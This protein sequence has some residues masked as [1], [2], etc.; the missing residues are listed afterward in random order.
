MKLSKKEAKNEFEV[1]PGAPKFP[2]GL[3]INLDN[4]SL[5]KLGF[6]SLP[7]V[8][9][10]FIVVGIGPVTH[11]SEHRRQGDKVDRSITIQLESIEVGPVNE[12]AETAVEV[13]SAAIDDANTDHNTD[14]NTGHKMKK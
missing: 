14:H 2:H 4:E 3:T 8:G 1:A 7:D 13:V 10:D 9:E 12:E 5:Q 6:D 11:A